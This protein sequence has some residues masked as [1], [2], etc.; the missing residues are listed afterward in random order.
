MTSGTHRWM[1][2]RWSRALPAVALVAAVTVPA[3]G[4]SVTA[5]NAS[6]PSPYQ[7]TGGLPASAKL[8]D[9]GGIT[10]RNI[11]GGHVAHGI[12]G[13]D[14]IPNFS[15]H[16]N[17]KGLNLNGQVQNQW[18]TNF[19]GTLPQHGGTT[20]INAPIIPVTVQLLDPSG[21]VFLSMSAAPYESESADSPVFSP[22]TWS[23]SSTPT[24]LPDAIQRAEFSRSAKADWHTEL[25]PVQDP[26][27]VIQLPY[28]DYFYELNSDGSCCGVIF[29]DVFAWSNQ[30]DNIVNEAVNDGTITTKDIST[31]LF[32][33]TL[34]YEGSPQQL[35]C[36]AGFH[37]Y[38]YNDL[39]NGV[40]QRWVLNFS[41]W[42]TPGLFPVADDDVNIISHEIAETF[43]DPF[44][45]LDNVHGVTPW[46]LSPNGGCDDISEVGDVVENLPDQTYT[47]TMDGFTYHPQNVALMQWFETGQPSDALDGAYSYPDTSV[48]TSPATFQNVNCSP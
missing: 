46:W 10:P 1:R 33:N 24:E 40:E 30:F 25:N 34:L 6:T 8:T 15:S 9:F 22:A 17:V 45:A 39:P 47:V 29:A 20:T 35:C 36:E 41:T 11:F 2:I 23:S 48:L 32:P 14:T 42:V 3:A 18:E 28:G 5:A 26:A 38:A 16:F 37:T 7:L 13:L 12:S 19:V 44:D 4:A 21:Q 43:N 31:F 27:V